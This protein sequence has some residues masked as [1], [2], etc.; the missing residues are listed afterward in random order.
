MLVAAYIKIDTKYNHMSNG[1]IFE[2]ENTSDI[3]FQYV[4]SLSNS[5]ANRMELPSK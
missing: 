1:Y 3:I 5:L 2:G 4:F